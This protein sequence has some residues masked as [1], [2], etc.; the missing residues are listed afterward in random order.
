M[1]GYEPHQTRS[2]PPASILYAKLL[3]IASI[4]SEQT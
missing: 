2:F 3:L 1:K 4:L